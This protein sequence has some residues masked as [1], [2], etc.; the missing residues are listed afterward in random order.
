M[1]AD[2]FTAASP[3]QLP[4]G[5]STDGRNVCHPFLPTVVH[6]AHLLTPHLDGVDGRSDIPLPLGMSLSKSDV[7]RQLPL[8]LNASH[9]LISGLD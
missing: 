5:K 8:A 7:I 2:C 1:I 4:L 6:L 3:H 9:S